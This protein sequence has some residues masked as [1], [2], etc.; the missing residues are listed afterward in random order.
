MKV[1]VRMRHGAFLNECWNIIEEAFR[2]FS[3]SVKYSESMQHGFNTRLPAR[4]LSH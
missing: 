3:G 2:G 4:G 1:I